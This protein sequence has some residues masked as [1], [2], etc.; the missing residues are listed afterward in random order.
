MNTEHNQKSGFRV[1]VEATFVIHLVITG[2]LLSMVILM[3][4]PFNIFPMMALAVECLILL[5]S[6]LATF[7]KLGE[8]YELFNWILCIFFILMSVGIIYA[9]VWIGFIFELPSTE[10]TRNAFQIP[11]GAGVILLGTI[12][13]LFIPS[14]I[15]V[16]KIQNRRSN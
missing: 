6:G 3:K 2:L 12:M 13:L 7:N 9:G 16:L 8:K 1:G 15:V 4:S 14:F 11:I 10:T 5:P